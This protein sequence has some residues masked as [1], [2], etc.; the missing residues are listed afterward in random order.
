MERM[1]RLCAF[2]EESIHQY[3]K[4]NWQNIVTVRAKI[5]EIREFADR[6]RKEPC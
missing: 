1:D 6:V 2:M 4:V 5:G 3:L